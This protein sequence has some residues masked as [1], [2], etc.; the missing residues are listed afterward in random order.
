LSEKFFLFLENI[1]LS[2]HIASMGHTNNTCIRIYSMCGV[3]L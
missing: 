3:T 1:L 2:L